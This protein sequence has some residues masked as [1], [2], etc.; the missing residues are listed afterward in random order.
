MIKV[1]FAP[2]PTGHLHIGAA[3]T[4][5]YNWLFARHHQGLFILRIEDTDRE[6]STSSMTEGIMASLSWLGID[7]DLGPIYQSQRLSLYR[8]KAEELVCAGKAYYCYCLP[9]EIQT[10]REK[11]ALKGE[12]WLYDRRC[13]QLS[14]E[15]IS[16]REAKGLPRAV[17]FKVPDE[18]IHYQDLILGSIS[19]KNG[20]LEDFVLI[21]SDNLP[22]YHLSVVVDDKE[23]GITHIIRGADHISNTPKQILLY[24]AFG[25]QV[26]AFAHQSLILGPD[27]KKLSKR[28]GVTSVLQFKKDGFLPIALFNSL[29]QMSWSPG[30]E[31]I[32]SLDEL[33]EKF[34]LEKRSRGNP[35]FDLK[36]LEWLNSQVISHMPAVELFPLVKEELINADLWQDR[37]DSEDKRWFSKLIDLLKERSH[38]IP[39]FSL[40]AL[41][42]LSDNYTFEVDAIKKYLLDERIGEI[43]PKLR[44][45]FMELENFTAGE[46]EECLRWRADKEG[47]KAALLIHAARVLLLGTRVGPGVF[48]VLELL[49]RAKTLKRLGKYTEII[50]QYELVRDG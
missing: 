33:V 49:G 29:V 22:T 47:V 2:S 43:L 37:L 32:Y 25:A 8:Q 30:E 50:S 3:R 13:R 12:Y 11:S 19:V 1:R 9:Q 38:R 41:P 4:A 45:D 31:K 21:R 7:W 34:S 42:F 6:R 27:K 16:Q 5:I 44:Q 48:A 35:V 26:P 18:D 46:I 28:H 15:E 36:K 23:L 17:R 39:E 24:R 20:T 14:P 10:R 40:R